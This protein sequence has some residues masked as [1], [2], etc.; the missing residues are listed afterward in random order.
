MSRLVPV[1]IAVVFLFAACVAGE[2]QGQDVIDVP[3]TPLETASPPETATPAP[4]ETAT[5]APTAPPTPEPPMVKAR[6]NTLNVRRVPDASDDSTVLCKLGYEEKAEYLGVEGKFTH[7]RLADGTEGYCYSD[8]LV[9]ADETLYAYLSPSTAQKVDE[10]TGVP[11]FEADGVTPVMVKN[12]LVDLRLY[13]PDAVY[14]LLFATERN[15]A[16]YP[17]YPRAIPLLQ[18]DTA[19]K[20]KKAFDLFKADGYTLKICDAY[21]PKS[22]QAILYDIV[23]NRH[24]IA[25]PLTTASNHNR[26]CAVDISLIDDATGRELEF[27]TPMHT[28]TDESAR[29]CKTWGE[30]ARANVDYLTRIMGK[31][32]L[33]GIQS[34]WWHYADSN[35]ADYMTTDIDFTSLT[36][37]PKQGD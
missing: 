16:G 7:V 11:V 36:M 23:Q 13:L 26:G 20:L 4:T 10:A 19:K 34:E 8:Y 31:C 32:G 28:F 22:V 9:D 35:H 6:V 24:W 1:I 18:K 25:N 15:V 5:A 3:V 30:T 12:E 21:R 17:L 37:L 33:E 14:E 2:P 27:P 29:T